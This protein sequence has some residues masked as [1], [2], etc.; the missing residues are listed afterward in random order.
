MKG[1]SEHSLMQIVE[2]LKRDGT[3]PSDVDMRAAWEACDDARDLFAAAVAVLGGREPTIGRAACACARAALKAS[4]IE[5]QALVAAL[6]TAEKWLEGKASAQ[7][8]EAAHAT[9]YVLYHSG[10][11]DSSFGGE[12]RA[13]ATAAV[14]H[15]TTDVI[16]SGDV[17]MDAANAIACSSNPM[18]RDTMRVRRRAA[19]RVLS[20]VVRANVRWPR[21][22]LPSP[23]E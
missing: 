16:E 11:P 10:D 6:E 21:P 4:R 1:R 23:T 7:D 17:A 5:T 19:L 18:D 13:S 9:A 15:A 12:A 14:M 3:R 2:D 20:D 22:M 8:L